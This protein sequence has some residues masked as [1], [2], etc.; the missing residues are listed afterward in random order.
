MLVFSGLGQDQ[1]PRGQSFDP[2]EQRCR[3]AFAQPSPTFRTI[4][5][6]PQPVL[7]PPG[8]VPPTPSVCPAGT[9]LLERQLPTG[10]STK[11]CV[12][13]TTSPPPV[14]VPTPPTPTPDGRFP[15]ATELAPTTPGLPTNASAVTAADESG[16]PWWCWLLIAAGVGGTG[17]FIYYGV[18]RLR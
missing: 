15:G 18:K 5:P 10:G 3:V 7:T 9:V 16:C 6:A 17:A 2:I 4:A 12:P 13:V 14:S 8:L 1:C 11:V